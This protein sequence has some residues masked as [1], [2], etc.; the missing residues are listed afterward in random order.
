MKAALNGVPSLSILDGWWLEGYNG[1]NGW[2]FGQ[3]E[4]S[5]NRDDTD[6]EAVYKI[7]EEQIIPMYY[8]ISEDG[9]PHEWVR[10][11]K[12]AI[13]S[14]APRYSARRMVKEYA[15]NFYVEAIKQANGP[16]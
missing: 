10:V 4:A 12:E 8:K 7:L 13:K 16:R 14:C 2:A 5:G 3:E 1:H 6:A 9:T 11:M 15:Q